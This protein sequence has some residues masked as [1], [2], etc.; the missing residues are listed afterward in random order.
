MDGPGEDSWI[1]L[2]SS[3]V[4]LPIWGIQ[5]FGAT[6]RE[7]GSALPI[8]TAQPRPQGLLVESQLGH[9]KPPSQRQ[10]PSAPLY[11]P[12]GW[13]PGHATSWAPEAA[14]KGSV[15]QPP[16]IPVRPGH[17]FSVV[18]GWLV[19]A[20]RLPTAMTVTAAAP[21]AVAGRVRALTSVN[22]EIAIAPRRNRS[23]VAGP[24]RRRWNR[25]RNMSHNL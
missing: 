7:L 3:V 15:A 1:A 23:A 19:V 21:G 9:H 22:V 24:R 25:G 16:A 12:Q 10:T 18:P 5:S 20:V 8:E 17:T 4:E 13:V 11:G 6:K 14:E 2:P